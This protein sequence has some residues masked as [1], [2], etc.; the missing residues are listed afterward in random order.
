MLRIGFHCF[1]FLRVLRC[2]SSPSTLPQPMNSVTDCRRRRRQGFPIRK[3]PDQSLL[4][5]SP[6]L[7]AA[8]YALHRLH[9]PRHPPYALCNLS[10]FA[11]LFRKTEKR[12]LIHI[13]LFCLRIFLHS[14]SPLF[15]FR[16]LKIN[17]K[18][19]DFGF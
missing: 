10:F 7:I 9:E 1:L 16:S 2:F 5:N 8:C 3:S 14:A 6:K 13:N 11:T 19:Y 15:S 18:T 17:R 4:D 12:R